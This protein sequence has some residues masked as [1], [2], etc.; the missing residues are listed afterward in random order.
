MAV[1]S[2]TLSGSLTG[3]GGGTLCVK[4]QPQPGPAT[5]LAGTNTVVE[6]AIVGTTGVTGVVV[7]E[8]AGGAI[9]T[10]EGPFNRARFGRGTDAGGL[11]TLRVV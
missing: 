7:I 4:D 6:S 9:T 3:G 1:A 10:G 8:P 5:S 2:S 11:T